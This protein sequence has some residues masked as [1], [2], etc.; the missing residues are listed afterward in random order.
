MLAMMLSGATAAIAAC[1]GNGYLSGSRV[2]SLLSGQTA[3]S[4]AFCSGSGSGANCKWQENHQGTGS[5][6]LVEQ[7]TGD[8]GDPVETVGTWSVQN[9]TGIITH[10][11][12]SGGSFSY[13]VNDNKDGTYSFCGAN[14]EFTFSV[15]AGRC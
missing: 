4:P 9:N 14:G 2:S 13:S 11:Y 1:P 6:S 3:C 5:G 12:G 15:K 10:N 8:P 7:H